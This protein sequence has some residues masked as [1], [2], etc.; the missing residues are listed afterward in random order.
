MFTG[1]PAMVRN[2]PFAKRWKDN[3]RFADNRGVTHPGQRNCYAI[4]RRTT[5]RLCGS[6]VNAKR[7][8]D[9]AAYT[10]RESRGSTARE[11]KPPVT[12]SL[13]RGFGESNVV[14]LKPPSVLRKIPLPFVLALAAA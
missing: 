6:S 4:K 3:Y 5:H 13:A 9:V 10:V 7:P 14:Q 12:P 8:S 11:F 2:L 1:L